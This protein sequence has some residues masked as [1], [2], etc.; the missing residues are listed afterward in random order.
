MNVKKFDFL[1]SFGDFT[2]LKKLENFKNFLDNNAINCQVVKNS[3]TQF[4]FRGIEKADFIKIKNYFYKNLYDNK[5][6][7]DLNNILFMSYNNAL[8]I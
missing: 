4:I 5:A 3:L 2:S 1:L 7:Y 8:N 6:L